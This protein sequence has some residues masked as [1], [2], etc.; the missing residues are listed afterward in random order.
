MADQGALPHVRDWNF[1]E[2]KYGGG[3]LGLLCGFVSRSI[4]RIVVRHV[5]RPARPPAGSALGCRSSHRS[6]LRPSCVS[7]GC[8]HD[9]VSRRRSS[10]SPW[11]RFPGQL[12]VDAISRPTEAVLAGRRN[13]G[14]RCHRCLFCDRW[15][16]KQPRRH[17]RDGGPAATSGLSN[18]A[19]DVAG[20]RAV[21]LGLGNFEAAFPAFRTADLGSQG[22]WD[23]AHSTPLEMLVSAGIP[24]T[25]LVCGLAAF[26]FGRMIVG[27]FARR[28]DNYI[29]ATGA[30]VFLL[31][32]LHSSVDFS[33]QVT[34]F[35]VLFA[36][37]IGCGLAQSISSLER[38]PRRFTIP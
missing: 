37:I 20:P 33:V 29:P 6:L 30:A 13:G 24:L 28:R 1:C 32:A 31:G 26:F 2:S 14:C 4:V 16:G 38:P 12:A 3:L 22:I 8:W 9:G 10:N 23:K 21:R 36:A 7:H 5:V 34:G 27:S 19:R 25:I 11:P 15:N 35:A 17:V 18:I